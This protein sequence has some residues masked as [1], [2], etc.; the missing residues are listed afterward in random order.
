MIQIR[1]RN[2]LCGWFCAAFGG[3]VLTADA[4]PLRLSER[5]VEIDGFSL[6]Y[7]E[8][9]TKAAPGE[10]KAAM[11]SPRTGSCPMS[12]RETPRRTCS[13]CG[14]H[15][16]ALFR[17]AVHIGASDGDPFTAPNPNA[18]SNT[19]SCI[20][21]VTKKVPGGAILSRRFGTAHCSG[22]GNVLLL[23]DV[24]RPSDSTTY[25]SPNPDKNAFLANSS[26]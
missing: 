15:T 20:D 23:A 16:L 7:P 25:S 1:F 14:A 5:G 26:G 13:A 17:Q 10:H 21:A 3:F 12:I 4:G 2:T 18:R 6:A 22:L 9:A 8:I 11:E 19:V 24:E